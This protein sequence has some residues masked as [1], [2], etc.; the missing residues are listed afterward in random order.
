MMTFRYP[1]RLEGDGDKIEILGIL[2]TERNR[3]LFIRTKVRRYHL[4]IA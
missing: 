3:H 2:F 1:S 4:T